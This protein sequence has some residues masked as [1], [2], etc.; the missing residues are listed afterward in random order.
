[1]FRSEYAGFTGTSYAVDTGSGT[2]DE[3]EYENEEYER[4]E[5]GELINQI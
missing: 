1:M 4:D 2:E 5:Y 3:E